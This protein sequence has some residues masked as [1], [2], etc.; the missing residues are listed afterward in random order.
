MSNRSLF[1][2]LHI[3]DFHFSSRHKREQ[4][5]VTDALVRD[6]EKICIGHRRPDLIFFTGDM[7]QAGGIDLHD[8]AYDLMLDRV[9]KITGC[10]DERIFIAPGNHDVSSK[11][12][13]VFS[14]ETCEWRK[15][16]GSAD[17]ISKL[18]TLYQERAFD[19]ALAEKFVHYNSLEQYLSVGDGRKRVLQ[20][21]FAT[22][23]HIEALN[24]DAVVLNTAA[25]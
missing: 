23:D 22:V 24:V 21:P 6:L 8:E 19:Q 7:V 3:S 18:N 14:K 17:E 25:F 1:T 10:S 16:I 11:A 5:I 4:V 13:E 2:I 15:I 9:S 20:T 12:V